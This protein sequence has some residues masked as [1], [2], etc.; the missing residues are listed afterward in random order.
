MNQLPKEVVAFLDGKQLEEKQHTA[1][2][3][4]TVGKDGFPY[5]A[6]LSVGE[7]LSRGPSELRIGL[8]PSTTTVE[9][10]I[11]SKQTTLMLVLPPKAYDIQ[12][13][14]KQVTEVE[15]LAILTGNVVHVKVDQAPYAKIKSSVVYELNDSEAAIS[16][17][18]K[19]LNR[20]KN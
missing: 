20:L 4:M 18:E 10:T 19:K 14:I 6:M 7:V 3:F 13:L 9:N 8:W 11:R 15:D 5:K 17:W 12:L 1:M 2:H 16:N